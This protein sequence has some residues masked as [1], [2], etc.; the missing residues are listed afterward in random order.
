[1]FEYIGSTQW[2]TKFILQAEVRKRKGYELYLDF[3]KS[4]SR[5]LNRSAAFS[6]A[7][8]VASCILIIWN[9]FR[10]MINM[11]LAI[12]KTSVLAVPEN[13]QAEVN[14]SFFHPLQL[15]CYH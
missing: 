10:R 4:S 7:F 8:L 12:L 14:G 6:W 2:Q 5:D 11:T 13:L 15:H 9:T 1:M 3:A